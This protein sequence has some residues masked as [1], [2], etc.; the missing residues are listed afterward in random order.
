VTKDHSVDRADGPLLNHDNPFKLGVFGI[1]VSGGCSMTS[2]EGTIE[3][4]WDETR[5]LAVA[6]D[7]AGFDALVPVARWKGFGGDTNFNDRSFETFTWAAAVAA[8]TSRIQVLATVHVPTMH[9]VRAA[10]E[11]ATVDHVSGGRL[12]LNLVAGWNEPEFAMFGLEQRE[13]D[14]RYEA[15]DEW[16]DFATRLWT[17]DTFD[18]EGKYVSGKRAHSRPWPVQTPRPLIMSA[19]AS[20]R[21]GQFAARNADINF[22]Q[23]PDVPGHTP[24]AD[25]V[26][27]LAR[28]KYNREIAIMGMA[29][30]VCRDTEAEARKYFDYFV[31]EKG[32]WA[33]AEVGLGL[34]QGQSQ[35]MDYRHNQV[36]INA[37][38]GYTGQPLIGIPEQ[39]VDGILELQRAGLDGV[40][41]SWVDYDEGIRQYQDQLLPLLVQAGLRREDPS[42]VSR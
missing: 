41:L 37:I 25:A 26:R 42:V 24:K 15:A 32:D 19:G 12:G 29:Y 11:A 38:A 4:D 13:H 39:V 17:E 21:G 22:I 5:R 20:G 35:S 31:H 9:P 3:V 10:K 33:G 40:T 36:A 34:A 18:F 27:R 16:V 23:A 1:N 14:D 8:V 6:A 30:V 7:E 28:E 2:A